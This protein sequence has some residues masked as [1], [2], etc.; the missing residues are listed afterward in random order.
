MGI[1]FVLLLG[2]IDLSAGVIGG[3]GAGVMAMLML[4]RGLPWYLAVA[5]RAARRCRD[6]PASP[7]CWCPP[8][9][10]LRSSSPS[11]HSLPTRVCCCGSSATAAPSRSATGDLRRS[12]TG[13]CRSSFGWIVVIVSIAAYAAVNLLVYRRRRAADLVTA[14]LV[15]DRAADRGPRRRPARRDVPAEP[16]PR[17]R[18]HRPRGHPVDRAA[19]RRAA[20]DLDLRAEPHGVRPARLRRRRQRRGRPPGRHPGRAD[21]HRLLRDQLR[22][23]GHL[24]HRRRVPA[25][26]GD[27]GRRRRQHPA[28]RGRRRG[29]RRHV[30]VR[31][32][33]QGAGRDHRRPG[34]RRHRQRPRACSACRPTSSSSSP[35]SCCC[36]RPAS[37]RSA[38]AAGPAPD[39]DRTDPVD[40]PATDRCTSAAARH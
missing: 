10:S 15:G 37:M 5:D 11:R 35:A 32:Q 36:S 6:G 29:H 12:P 2:H 8:S 39:A 34:H 16:E 20:G 26:L 22:H 1:G 24:R 33:G 19:G 3:V 40:A 7:A 4:K 30:A 38:G 23:G 31:W 14:P 18:Q 28:L 21:H 13:T 17:P 27:P 25:Q 9:A